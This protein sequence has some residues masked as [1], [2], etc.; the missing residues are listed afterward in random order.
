MRFSVIIPLEFH[1][2]V[3]DRCV[4]GWSQNQTYAR[5]RYEVLVAVPQDHAP[6]QVRE[7]AAL[8]GAGDRII[9]YPARHDM[10]LVVAAANVALGSHLVFT[11]SHC[12]PETDFLEQA[13]AVLAEHPDW[14]GFSGRGTPVTHNLLS[15]IEAEM[16][17]KHILA[18][19]LHHEWLKLRDACFVVSKADYA[20]VGGFESQY[21]HFAEWLLAARFYRANLVLGYDPRPTVAHYYIGDFSTLE[22]FTAD[23][24]LGE[25]RFA[26]NSSDDNCLDLFEEIPTWRKQRDRDPF[27]SGCILQVLLTDLL[28]CFDP[29]DTGHS[30][31]N[32]ANW[33]WAEVLYWF[34]MRF[35]PKNAP[36]YFVLRWKCYRS[37]RQTEKL[38]R[39]GAREAAA[40]KFL[41]WLRQCVEISHQKFL[42][43]TSP[44]LHT[45]PRPVRNHSEWRAG[46]YERLATAGMHALERRGRV[47]FRWSRP[48]AVIQLPELPG[49]V[50]ITIE[51]AVPHDKKARFYLV[52]RGLAPIDANHLD[53]TV[54]EL[55]VPEG[56][57]N[58]MLALVSGKLVKPE[59]GRSLGVAIASVCCRTLDWGEPLAGQSR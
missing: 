2:G 4:R 31:R 21:G 13:D 5:D 41:Q 56:T 46:R 24:A 55:I 6:D 18:N 11:E 14:S 52:G 50:R 36:R 28:R 49:P 40:A 48:A 58:A 54:T 59:D 17:E 33:P 57:A 1:R 16:Y 39:R 30:P 37:R 27:A 32:L 45:L 38:L 8:L 25:M 23:F 34:G 9:R 44:S 35:F 15:E 47:T 43:E 7:I 42:A 22:E 53:D 20:R 10:D 3:A 19:M 26:S 12:F 51:W 29:R